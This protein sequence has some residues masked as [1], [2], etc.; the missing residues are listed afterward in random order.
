MA[1]T[2]PRWTNCRRPGCS[3]KVAG[4]SATE[5]PRRSLADDLGGLAP[6]GEQHE[7]EDQEPDQEGNSVGGQV[8]ALQEYGSLRAVQAEHGRLSVSEVARLGEHSPDHE[9]DRHEGQRFLEQVW[10][11][12]PLPCP[13]ADRVAH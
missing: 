12:A 13:P 4:W 3:C 1:S 7:V 5:V 8:Q 11:A 9:R 6:V 10:L 2:A